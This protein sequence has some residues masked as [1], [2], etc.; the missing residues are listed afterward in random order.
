MIPVKMDESIPQQSPTFYIGTSGWTYDHW[1]GG[2]YPEKLPKSRWFEYYSAQFNAVEI[3]ATFYRA[4]KDQTYLKWKAQAPRGFGYVLKAPK[5]ISHLKLLKDTETD[6]H[7]FCASADLLEDKF[8][9]ILLQVSPSLPYDFGRLRSALLSFSDPARVAVEFR[10]D[11]W[12]NPQ[13]EHLLN[14]VGACFCNADSP[15][16]KLTDYLTSERAYLRL[17]G[18]IHWYST[19]YSNEELREIASLTRSLVSRGAKQVYIFFNNDFGGF[20]PENARDL[21]MILAEA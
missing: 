20:A 19:T 21:K 3:N 7:T 12:F 1:K 16:Q 8:Q 9:M 10:N 2:F 11:R 6:I 5:M 13:T 17:H 15:S 18:R 4:F 14:E